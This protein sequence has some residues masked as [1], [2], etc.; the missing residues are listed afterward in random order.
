MLTVPVIWNLLSKLGMEVGPF[1][2]GGKAEEDLA[3][4][5]L[6]KSFPW[7]GGAGDHN[8]ILQLFSD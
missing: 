3:G 4:H 5:S 2:L 1:S 6:T 8:V 7:R